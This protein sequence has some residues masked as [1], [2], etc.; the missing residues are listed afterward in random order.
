MSEAGS[1]GKVLEIYDID[2]AFIS[3]HKLREEHKRFFDSIHSNYRALTVC[4][5]SAIPSSGCGKDGVAMMYKKQCQFSVSLIGIHVNDRILGIK[6]DQRQMRPIYAVSEY[7][8]SVNYSLE[9]Y[10]ECFA[11]LQNLHETFSAVGIVLFLGDFNCDI[12]KEVSSD[13]RQRI[14][15]SFLTTKHMA[16]AP[17]E[18]QFTFRPTNKILDYVSIDESYG[19]LILQN[20][21]VDKDICIVSGHLPTFTLLRAET[22]TYI[23]LRKTYIT[24][25]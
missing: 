23:V 13:N 2:F 3:E 4:D 15:N 8:P 1:L 11:N 19:N 25:N 22:A 6:I 21:A 18:S 24:W 17:L 9:D 20:V 14:F 16:V 10:C 5:S 7:M 12:Y